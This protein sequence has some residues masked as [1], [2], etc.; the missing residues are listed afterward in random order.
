MAKSKV[1][2]F[3]VA[4]YLVDTMRLTTEQH[5]AYLLLILDYWQNGPLGMMLFC[6]M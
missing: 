3:H 1:M 2:P 5:G 6:A 4:D